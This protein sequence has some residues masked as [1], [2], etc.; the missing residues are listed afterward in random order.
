MVTSLTTNILSWNQHIIHSKFQRKNQNYRNKVKEMYSGVVLS[1]SW[2]FPPIK[3]S[4]TLSILKI[5]KKSNTQ[6]PNSPRFVCANRVLQR[7]DPNVDPKDKKTME[8]LDKME[9]CNLMAI[10]MWIS[11]H[12]KSHYRNQLLSIATILSALKSS[13]V[14]RFFDSGNN[15]CALKS[16]ERIDGCDKVAHSGSTSNNND[17]K[18]HSIQC[19][20]PIRSA[21]S[22]YKK[23]SWPVS[24]INCTHIICFWVYI[25]VPVEGTWHCS[26]VVATATATAIVHYSLFVWEIFSKMRETRTTN[27]NGSGANKQSQ[28]NVKAWTLM[29]W[30]L[31]E[32]ESSHNRR[33]N[34]Q[35]NDSHSHTNIFFL[36]SLALFVHSLV[37]WVWHC[38]H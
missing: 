36:L 13:S 37:C 5:T 21:A 27:D 30:N 24:W 4:Q 10:S 8:K 28:R 1:S 9:S 33:T 12:L 25:F 26:A 17:K 7:V 19:F 11:N 18:S 3:G 29:K 31:H 20:F 22:L 35:D 34:T 6:L 15:V 23:H 14:N 32:T 16:C 38:M 2:V